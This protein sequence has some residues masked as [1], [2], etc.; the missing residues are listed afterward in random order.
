[1]PPG[2]SLKT[3]AEMF[4]KAVE[5]DPAKPVHHLEYARTLKELAKYSEARQQLRTCIELPVVHWDDPAH[6]AETSRMLEEIKDKRD[7]T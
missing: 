6:K 1:V 5:I 4:R 3:A 7:R 2:A